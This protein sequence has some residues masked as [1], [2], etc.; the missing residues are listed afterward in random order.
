MH[1]IFTSLRRWID[2]MLAVPCPVDPLLAM[3]PHELADL[4]V[5]HP[6]AEPCGC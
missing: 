3:T 6:R 4:P 5:S 2:S 1:N